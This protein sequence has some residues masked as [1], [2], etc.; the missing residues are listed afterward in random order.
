M[1]AAGAAPA[2]S[3]AAPLSWWSVV[4]MLF[5][6]A[7]VLAALIGSVWLLRRF[8]SS[9]VLSRAPLKVVGGV[10]LGGRERVVVVEAG[11]RWLV[12][13]V[14]GQQVSLLTEMPRAETPAAD[15]PNG[16]P[17]Q[18]WLQRALRKRSEHAPG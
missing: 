13:G 7:L 3:S 4:Q 14:T 5:S 11:E 1:S 18:Q 17:F 10:S 2:P 8:S 16:P 9:G 15:G 6:L 12:L